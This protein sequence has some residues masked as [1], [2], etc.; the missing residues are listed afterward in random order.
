MCFYELSTLMPTILIL[1]LQVAKVFQPFH[2][3]G[4]GRAQVIGLGLSIAKTL[5]EKM[6]GAIQI[7]ST[8]GVGSVFSFEL[9]FDVAIPQATVHFTSPTVHL[10]SPGPLVIG[11]TQSDPMPNTMLFSP[12]DSGLIESDTIPS[13]MPGA[14]DVSNEFRAE[15]TLPLR[16]LVVDDNEL[17]KTMFEVPSTTC[18][19]N[20]IVPS[21]CIHLLQTVRYLFTLRPHS[22]G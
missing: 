6:G 17:N 5:V 11:R 12:R 9:E 14:I 18:S 20:S 3:G 16:F 15:S 2:R 1:R 7:E 13:A 22:L 19:T 21:P 8:P 10:R 4:E